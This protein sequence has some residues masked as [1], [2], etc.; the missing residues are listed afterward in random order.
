MQSGLKFPREPFS[1]CRIWEAKGS[2]RGLVG[3]LCISLLSATCWIY[4]VFFKGISG[5]LKSIS[6]R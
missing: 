2:R 1:K 6:C 4:D 3:F 5:D